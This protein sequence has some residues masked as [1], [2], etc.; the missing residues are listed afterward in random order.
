MKKNK[1]LWILGGIVVLTI[2]LAL[3]LKKGEPVTNVAVEKA[4][5]R[6]ITEIVSVNGKIQP[7][8]EIKISPDVSGEIIEMSVKEGDSVVAGQLLL[9]INPDIY[10][11]QLNQQKA[12]LQNGQAALASQ[13]AQR[14]SVKASLIQAESNYQ[15]V[16]KLFDSK[17]SSEQELEQARLQ[18]ETAKASLATTEKNILAAHYSVLSLGASLEQGRKNLG[19]TSIYAPTSGIITNLNSEQGERVVGTAQM[20]GTEIMRISNLNSMEVEVN[21][22]ENDIV[23][24][25]VGD[26]ADVRADA[27]PDRTFKGIVTEIANSARFEATSIAADQATNYVVKVRILPFSYADLGIGSKQPFRSGMTATVDIRT[28]SKDNVLSIPISAVTTREPTS[29]SGKAKE[30]TDEA[31]DKNKVTRTWVFLYQDGKAKAVEV[32]T[33]LQDINYFEV[34][35]GVKPGDEVISAPGMAVAKKLNDGDK[36]KKVDKDKV[37]ENSGS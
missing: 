1:K 14:E 10:E 31:K 13:E 34:L 37:F 20:A 29:K 15:R 24:V 32:K 36:V 33:G 9:R 3:L 18:Y 25:H 28:K 7:E 5:Q 22:N 8:S 26:S 21:V 4:T 12:N 27:Y 2:L 11:S 6:T 17:V 19:R 30:I 23:R 35:D 16:K